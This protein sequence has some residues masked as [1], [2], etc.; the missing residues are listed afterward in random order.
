MIFSMTGFGRATVEYR[1]NKIT[2]EVKSLNSKQLDL[3]MREPPYYRELEPAMRS[4]LADAL[5]RAHIP[6]R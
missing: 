6:S 3:Q 2:A 1:M 5:R 4:I